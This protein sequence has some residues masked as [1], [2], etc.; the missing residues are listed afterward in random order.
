M[1]PL[2]LL[3]ADGFS[4]LARLCSLLISMLKNMLAVLHLH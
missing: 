4:F 2:T 3:A 1:H